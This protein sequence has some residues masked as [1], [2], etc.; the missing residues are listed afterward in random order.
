MIEILILIAWL[1]IFTIIIAATYK[2]HHLINHHKNEGNN[3]V[4][5]NLQTSQNWFY[6]FIIIASIS[7]I[8]ILYLF[9]KDTIY[10]SHLFE[11]LNLTIRLIHITFGIAWIGASFYFVFLENALNRTDNVRDELAGNLWAVHG[12]GFYYLEKYKL[13]PKK[14]PKNL[15]WFK[16]EAYFTWLSGFSL[17]TVVYYFNAKSFLIDPEVLDLQPFQAISISIISLIIGWIAYDLIC[18]KLSNNKV[19][20]TI[21]ITVLVFFFAWFYSQVFSGRASYIHFGALL[22]TLMAANVFFIIIPGQKRMVNAA[23]KGLPPN[24][25]D[26]KAA[27]LRSYTNNYFTLPVLFVMISNHFPSTFGNN[28]QWIVLIAITLGTAGVKHYLNIRE[29][30]Q[31]SVLVMPISVLILLG[32][33]FM[34]APVKPKYENCI[35]TVSFNDVVLIINKRCI[36]CHSSNPTDAIWKVAPNGVKYDTAEQIYNLKDKIFQRAVV[37]KNMPFNNNQTGMTQEERDMINCWMSQ[38]ALKE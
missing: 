11:W 20:F 1:I 16:Y 23:K 8:G 31:L 38:G 37:S 4:A 30:G 24:P 35:E 3:D 34:T 19:V 5:E 28:Y 2:T 22:G 10:E 29:K 25:E 14:I 6:T 36:T 32:A 21:A 12:G 26:G 15:H 13:A 9:L 33:A 18:K 17:L 7:G 27:F